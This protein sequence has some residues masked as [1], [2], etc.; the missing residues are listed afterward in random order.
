MSD[1]F[2]QGIPVLSLELLDHQKTGLTM[3]AWLAPERLQEAARRMLVKEYFLEDVSMLETT[4]GFVAVYHFDHFTTP[5]RIALRVVIGR[6]NPEL[7]SIAD[8]YHGADWHER[9]CHDFFGVSF[10]GHENLLP[11]LMP[12]D[13]T[14]YPLRKDEKA[15]KP[16]AELLAPGEMTGVVPG[17]AFFAPP[18]TPETK[19][20]EDKPVARNSDLEI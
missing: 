12:G 15:L 13:A 1:S 2:F 18:V 7:P 3:C 5:G 17:V 10:A 4:E 9:E 6:E 14:E 11:L 8:I 16:L 20:E 19:T